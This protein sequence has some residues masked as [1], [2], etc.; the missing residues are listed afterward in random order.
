MFVGGLV[1]KAVVWMVDHKEKCDPERYT[2]AAD[3]F[4]GLTVES[5]ECSASLPAMQ[6]EHVHHNPM[7]GG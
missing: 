7:R 4:L 3:N 2:A 6:A 1:D 5:Q